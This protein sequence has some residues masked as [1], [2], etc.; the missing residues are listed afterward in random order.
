MKEPIKLRKAQVRPIVDKVFPDYR[1][2]KFKLEFTDAVVFSDLHWDGGS[3]NSYGFVRA[4]GEMAFLPASSPWDCPFEGKKLPL[5][6]NIL[7]VQH[8]VVCGHDLGITIYAHP[9]WAP[10]LLEGR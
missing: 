9:C 10:K 1:G 3:R 6:Q 5:P 7:V 8:T 2:R 4:D